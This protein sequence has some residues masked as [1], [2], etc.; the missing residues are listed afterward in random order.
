MDAL[1]ISIV[2]SCLFG[3]I[4]CEFFH[5]AKPHILFIVA[6]DLGWND[7][8]W[9][10]PDMITPHLHKLASEGVILN[11]YYVQPMCSPS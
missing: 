10:N 3:C 11:N 6:D 4:Y 7:V 1:L 2:Y 9:H 5:G 8:S